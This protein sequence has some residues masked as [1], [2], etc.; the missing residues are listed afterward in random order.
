MA[1]LNDLAATQG[2]TDLANR[3]NGGAE[4][5]IYNH[6]EVPGRNAAA[7]GTVLV[8]IE[9]EST[10]FKTAAMV[11]DEARALI[12]GDGETPEVFPSAVA[13]AGGAPTYGDLVSDDGNTRWRVP[14]ADLGLTGLVSGNIVEGST[15]RIGEAFYI[16]LP[17]VQPE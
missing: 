3:F 16:S 1:E 12:N 10:A 4:L 14:A 11:G 9:L 6:T 5:R 13:V 7:A 8:T 17:A 2:V 15:V